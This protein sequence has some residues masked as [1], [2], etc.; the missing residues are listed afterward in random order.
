VQNEASR[1]VVELR[2]LSSEDVDLSG[3]KG[4]SLGELLRG[5][6]PVPDGFVL[7]TAA[8]RIAARQTKADPDD[9]EGSAARLRTAPVPGIVVDPLLSA[10]RKLGSVPVAVR[11]SATAEDL[12]GAS[13]AGQHDT[14]LGVAGEEAL[15]DAVR[16]CW[17]SL[18]NDRA[19]AYRKAKSVDERDLAMAVVVHKMVDAT[20]S[21]VLFTADPLTGTRRRAVI[22]AVPGLG[23]AL[24]SGDAD[25]DHFVVDTGQR[26]V[27]ARPAGGRSVLA[28]DELMALALLGERVELH[29]DA[30]QD[31]EFALDAQR[32]IW[33]VQSRRITT[34]YPLPVGIPDPAR[35]LRVYVSANV[36]QGYFEPL[37]PMGIQFFRLT[38]TGIARALGARVQDEAA[39][40]KT[41][42]DAGMRIYLDLTSVLRDPLGHRLLGWAAAAG[43]SRSSAVLSQLAHDPRLAVRSGSRLSSLWRIVRRLLRT[44]MPRAV[45]YALLSPETARRRY[46]RELEAIAHA[47]IP[48]DSDANAR[49]D[50][51]ERL[52]LE[53]PQLML[54]RVAGTL[55]P[56]MLSLGLAARL[57][58]GRATE[59][60]LRTTTLSAP[61]NPTTEMD[62]ALWSVGAAARTD[63]ESRR[64]LLE[65]PPADL[66]AAYQART[67]P[68]TLQTGLSGFL[69]R[70]GFRCIGEIDIGMPRWSEDPTHLLGALANYARLG[71]DLADPGS[72]FADGAREAEAMAQNLLSRVRGPR[73][74]VLRFALRRLRALIGSREAP[75]F[76]IIRLLATPARELLK[77]VGGQLAA[78]GRIPE[79]ADVYF[80]TIPEARRGLAGEDLRGL[81]A[82]RRETF[83]R[84]LTR[85]HIPRILLSDGTDAETMLPA[86]PP[87]GGLTGAPASPGT[88]TGRARVILSPVG[89]HIEP[90]EILV[91]PSTN[92]GWTPLFLTAGGLV[93]EMGGAMSHGAVVAREYGIPAVVGVGSATEQ[94]RTGMTLTIDGSAGT[95]LI[96]E[97]TPEQPPTVPT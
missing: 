40:P 53:A 92:P 85:K 33:L 2:D 55:P 12:P 60:E 4:A 83:E 84:E 26:A 62:L 52:L 23:E 90:G 78:Q 88:A 89:A 57:L 74:V 25:P 17:A 63:P 79:P 76:H 73:R 59:A 69:E 71:D 35:E 56:A 38:G 95:V 29:F 61:H 36:V 93:M 50:A 34:L 42:V 31:I 28:D 49:L 72:K 43:E 91:A 15:L 11:S 27:V 8:Y 19:V 82:S 41:V 1:L 81:V 97:S 68:P 32:R 87:N 65:R 75:K 7:T 10:Y 9:P 77:T 13:F 80:L 64:I 3:G 5:G 54:P 21:G 24:V 96:N 86:A 6:L 16:R 18:W 20:A 70:Y 37:T 67:L 44:G 51:M 66:A 22:D 48:A 58:R 39:G 14:Y 47:P 30:P 46:A 94:I 45:L